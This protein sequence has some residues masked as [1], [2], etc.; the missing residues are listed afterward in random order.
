MSSPE[1]KK[2]VLSSPSFA[3]NE[4]VWGPARG[5]PAWPGKIVVCPDG[6]T[7]PNDCVWI[8]W[9]GLGGRANIEMTS[10][11]GL[12]TLSEGLEAHHSALKDT[13]K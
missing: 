3:I 4:L 12:K 7:T 1:T 2:G 6:V 9:F 13:R 10:I 8:R 5:Y 11:N